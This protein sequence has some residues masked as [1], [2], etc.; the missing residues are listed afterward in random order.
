MFGLLDVDTWPIWVRFNQNT[1]IQQEVA[2]KIGK[3]YNEAGFDFV[4]FDGAEDVPP[5]YWFNVS[6]SQDKVYNQ[7]DPAPAF[8]EGALKSHFN[9][10]I[11]TRGN[12]FD[13][14]KPEV[15]K[16]AVVMHPVDEIRFIR[17]DFT[18]IDFGWIDYVQ[19][20]ENTIGLQP[21]MLEY[22]CSRAAAWDCPVS[23]E[24]K[25]NALRE[26]PRTADNLQVLKR[27]ED[28]RL[29]GYLSP[30]QKMAMRNTAQE[31][32][33]LVDE[34]GNPEWHPY[35][36]ITDVAGGD[37]HIRAFIFERAGKNW[38]V[39]WHTSGNARLELKTA[40]GHVHLFKTPG[41][42]LPVERTREG[43]VV[44]ASDRRYIET[45]LSR[46]QVIN[47]FKDATVLH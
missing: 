40:A 39:Y 23:L 5:P 45:D 46:D 36:Q 29:S 25:L 3:I 44:P 38:V 41:K 2:E 6:M 19:P 12:A 7:L 4:Y 16:E 10:H 47:L 8:S 14:F 18:A 27:W 32:I 22:I 20:D 13:V 24:G 21:D 17:Q 26:H 33:L 28:A 37:P 42:K 43:I 31:H 35:R 15:M 9:W 34:K 1:S 11:L 30:E